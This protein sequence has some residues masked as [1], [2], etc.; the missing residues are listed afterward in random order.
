MPGARKGVPA[1]VFLITDGK[2]NHGRPVIS[3]ARKLEKTGAKIIAVGVG[4][5]IDRYVHIDIIDFEITRKIN[6]A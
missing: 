4:K 5:H 1:F 3:E 2:S 6:N